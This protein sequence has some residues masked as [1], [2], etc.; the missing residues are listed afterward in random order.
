MDRTTLWVM[1]EAARPADHEDDQQMRRRWPR[2][3][4][5]HQLGMLQ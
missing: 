1:V 3:F 5:W 2:L 4:A